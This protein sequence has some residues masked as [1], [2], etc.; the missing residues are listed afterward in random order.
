MWKPQA[1]K[2]YG[3]ITPPILYLIQNRN[4]LSLD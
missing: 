2:N 3:L 1:M 4:L